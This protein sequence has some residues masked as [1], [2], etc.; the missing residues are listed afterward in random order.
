MLQFFRH[1][2]KAI[3]WIA[4]ICFILCGGYSIT[5][6]KKDGRFAGEVF[7]KSVTFQE[8]NQFYRA[9]QLFMPSEKPVEDPDLLRGYTWQ[10]IIYAREAK[11]EGL[12]VSD[13]DVRDEITSILKQQG[14]TDPTPQQ[15]NIWLTRSLHM[16]P[17]EF[18]EGL[19]EFIRIQRLLRKTIASLK[20]AGTE[21]TE[22]EKAKEEPAEKQKE[23]F[24]KW[25]AALNQK[26][27]LKDYLALPE[28]SPQEPPAAEPVPSK[29]A[30]KP[31]PPQ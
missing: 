30:P 21:K 16:T 9:T 24:M 29:P 12:K 26:A 23:A 28:A 22:K 2:T 1:H 8:Y 15:Y 10:N 13:Q 31:E 3:V 7:G 17:H 25:T 19:R 4:A 20:P 5:T 11:R 18:E 6:L 27:A 14:L